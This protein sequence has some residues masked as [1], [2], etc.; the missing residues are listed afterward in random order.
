MMKRTPQSQ[1]VVTKN[2]NAYMITCPYNTILLE[3]HRQF[4]SML[5][6]TIHP[7]CAAIF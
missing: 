7:F 2:S 3:F 1:C 5:Y 6:K 4:I